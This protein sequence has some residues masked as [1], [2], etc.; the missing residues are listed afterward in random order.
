MTTPTLSPA[1]RSILQS[2]LDDVRQTALYV[3]LNDETVA[4]H[5]L[6]DVDADDNR[7]YV[8]TFEGSVTFCVP[9]EAVTIEVMS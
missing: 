4:V 7:A 5:E 2:M 1:Q 8:T 6:V 9:M 3:K